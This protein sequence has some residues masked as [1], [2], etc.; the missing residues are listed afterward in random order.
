MLK[1]ILCVVMTVTEN[2]PKY[3]VEEQTDKKALNK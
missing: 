1:Q 2:Q 3:Q